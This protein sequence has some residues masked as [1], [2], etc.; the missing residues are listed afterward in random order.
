MIHLRVLIFSILPLCHAF[1]EANFQTFGDDQHRFFAPPSAQ[2]HSDVSHK[3]IAIVGAGSAGLGILKTIL[4]LPEDLRSGWD[5]I[6]YEQRRNVGGIWLPDP[7]PP[8][9]PNLPETPLYPRLMTN[10]PHPTM[11]YPGSP[12]PPG[13]PLFA[14][15]EYVEQYHIDYASQHNLTRF[16]HLNHTVHAA[17][18]LGNGTHGQW[19]VE[20]HR[21]FDG[22]I[23]EVVRR[24]FDHLIVASGHNQYPRLPEWNG[25]EDWLANSPTGGFKREF[26]HSIFYRLPEHYTNKTV[27]LVGNGASGGD[28]SMQLGPL[29][30]TYQSLKEGVEPIPGSN[31]IVK[32]TISHFNSSSIIFTDGSSLESVDTVIAATGYTYL[33]PFLTRAPTDSD[34]VPVLSTSP[35]THENCTTASSLV[36]NLRYV[37]PLYR[38]LISL[39]PQ[40]PPTALSFVGLPVLVANC[41]SD[42]AQ[43]LFLA[44]VLADP[45]ILPSRDEMMD[46]LVDRENQLRRLGYDPYIVGHR[47]VGG[48]EE[49]Q[50]YQDELV[51]YLKAQNKLPND[52]KKFVEQWR[53]D[54]RNNSFL[55]RR[56]WNH[57]LA[58]GQAETWLDGIETESQWAEMMRRLADWQLDWESD[59]DQ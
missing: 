42:I 25:T 35:Q 38:H 14:G 17:G 4:N 40:L 13:T 54:T 6:L 39:S 28:I 52:G 9:P 8:D 21:K 2:G 51:D 15:H 18:W 7:N 59:H 10:T 31:V 47:M 48:D 22:E 34:A 33:V 26:I 3:S 12:F 57:L 46:N 55:L 1:N 53:R 50:D 58:E 24:K 20:V 36:T 49:A 43:S 30:K 19:D 32:P 11:T 45:S 23:Q 56:A 16:I 27:V 41:P 5:I 44:H 37:F 29:T